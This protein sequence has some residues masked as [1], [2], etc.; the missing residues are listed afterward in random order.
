M[1]E[2]S[3]ERARKVRQPRPQHTLGG[4]S[5]GGVETSIFRA[6]W[7]RVRH[8]GIWTM[9]V[10]KSY[11]NKYL[12]LDGSRKLDANRLQPPLCAATS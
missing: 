1:T 8:E 9:E 12:A 10:L 7:K 2:Q 5:T 4:N 6:P 11:E 3:S